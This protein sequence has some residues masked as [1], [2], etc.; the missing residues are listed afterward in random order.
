[1]TQY[2]VSARASVAVIDDDE[3]VREALDGILRSVGL[4][5][6]S[7]S[8]P[9]DFLERDAFDDYGCII[10][11][12]RMPGKSGLDLQDELAR[13]NVTAPVIILTGHADVPMTVRAMKAGAAGFLT[14]PVRAQ[15]LLDG[16]E[17]A[18]AKGKVARSDARIIAEAKRLFESL[19]QR[20]RE[21]FEKVAT[22]QINKQI[23]AEL[24]LSEATVKLHRGIVMRKMQANSVADLVRLADRLGRRPKVG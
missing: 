2:T 12:V 23:G 7:F 1:M 22:G 6:V 10:L 20:E 21:V 11:D 8:S 19:S 16:V 13:R 4:Q 18:L 9:Q 24:G 3:S 15:D 17:E 5:V 14:K